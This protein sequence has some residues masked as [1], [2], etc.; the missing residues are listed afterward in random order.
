MNLAVPAPVSPTPTDHLA[1]ARAAMDAAAFQA[2]TVRV[3]V[4]GLPGPYTLSV[5][6]APSGQLVCAVRA[7]LGVK[8]Y[9]ATPTGY[10]ERDLVS[11]VVA[12]LMRECGT[13]RVSV[14]ADGDPCHATALATVGAM[15][16]ACG[17][18]EGVNGDAV[19]RIDAVLPGVGAH[20][21]AHVVAS[22]PGAA[23]TSGYHPAAPSADPVAMAGDVVTLTRAEAQSVLAALDGASEVAAMLPAWN[24]IAPALRTIAALGDAVA[25]V[26]TRAP[27]AQARVRVGGD[28]LRDR[29]NGVTLAAPGGAPG[30]VSGA[31]AGEASA[32]PSSATAL[33]GNAATKPAAKSHHAKRPTP[34]TGG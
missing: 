1:A 34:P 26:D 22:R 15:I 29:L 24:T 16:A 8:P 2:R 9:H 12:D 33:P 19:A 21:A 32:T 20:L 13:Y 27:I 28:V 17:G 23:R 30:A 5:T 3:Y 11:A 14:E 25:A 10:A 7:P 18:A 6:R 4:E 31:P